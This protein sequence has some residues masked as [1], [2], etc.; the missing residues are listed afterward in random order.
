M[1]QSKNDEKSSPKL[2]VSKEAPEEIKIAQQSNVVNQEQ[3]HPSTLFLFFSFDIVNSTA[4]KAMT[5]YWSIVMTAL[6]EE[7]RNKV[8]RIDDWSAARLWRVIGDEIIFF[9]PVTN[10]VFLK[11]YVKS[12]AEITQRVVNSLKDGT[13]F[14]GIENQ[15]LK[16]LDIQKLSIQTPLSVKTAM[17]VAAINQKCKNTFDCIEVHYSASSTN[18]S[19]LE[20]L[21]SDIDAGF[22]LKQYTQDRRVVISFELACLLGED[23]YT[24]LNIIGYVRLKGVWNE[25]PYPIIWYH[26]SAEKVEFSE[27]FRYDEADN[28]PI[29]AHYF[30]R[31]KGNENILN[32]KFLEQDEYNFSEDMYDAKHALP[33]IKEDKNLKGKIEYLESLYQ[34]KMRVL[35]QNQFENPLE[36]HCAVVCCDLNKKEVMIVH[37]GE[38]QKNYPGKWE[39]GC[40]KAKSSDPLK[41][42]IEEYYRET[43]AVDVELVCDQSRK[44]SQ[45]KPLAVYEIEGTEIFK[46]GIIFAGR[47]KKRDEYRG[48]KHH[49]E[50]KW[51]S[52]KKSKKYE[53]ESKTI[54]DF[55]KTLQDVFFD[56]TIWE[57]DDE[58]E[59]T[60]IS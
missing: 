13:F 56:T 12:V 59:S 8:Y 14:K 20:F 50:V 29:V 53:D 32:N 28:N 41:K 39:F 27:S 46:K 52:E 19:I 21:G 37:R 2:L 48:N 25:D 31:I 47:V 4:Y 44:D 36:L 57:D 23:E 49:D 1:M 9:I 38:G 26:D 7:I 33:K 11:T 17:W 42:T 45:P 60:N 58:R 51:V 40:A 24:K 30:S 16:S 34:E 6:L 15:N 18:Q 55:Y 35:Y 5:Y 43:Y 3:E 54:P 10:N 22:R